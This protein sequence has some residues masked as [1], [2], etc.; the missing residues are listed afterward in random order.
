MWFNEKIDHNIK[1]KEAIINFMPSWWYRNYGIEYG[2]KM[3]FDPDYRL[4]AYLTMRRFFYE[5][6][7]KEIKEGTDNPHP[8]VILPDFDNTFYQSMVGFDVRFPIDQY[9]MATGKLTQ[10]QIRALAVPND[11]WKVYPYTVVADQIRYLN[12]KLA[13]DHP[14]QMKTRGILNEAIQMCSTDFYCDLLDEDCEEGTSLVMNFVSE[15]LRR[16]VVDNRIRN[17]EFEHIMMNCTASVAGPRVYKEHVF[18]H[19]K[20]LY[21]FCM[22]RGIPVGIHHC[23]KFDDFVDIYSTMKRVSFV[24]IGHESA[25]RPVLERYPNAR[26]QYIVSTGLISN[27]TVAE[28]QD[29]MADILA[30]SEGC[31]DRFSV[32][33]ADLEFGMPDENVIAMIEALKK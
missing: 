25:I 18:A 27:G 11:L 33:C 14:L 2:R 21:D 23:G 5:R 4:E 16:Q 20:A 26:V 32:S 29:K 24:E 28:I 12:N 8:M 13:M 10:E 31:W 7:G 19:D 3:I 15:V 6:Y 22:M 9:P 1:I 17:P 30:Q